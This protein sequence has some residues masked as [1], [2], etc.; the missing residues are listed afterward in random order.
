MASHNELG[1]KGEALTEEY[2]LRNGYQVLAKNWRY[3]KAEIDIIAKKGDVLAIIEVK[4]RTSV[5]I[6]SPEAAVNSKKIKLL[7]A[8][9]NEYVIQNDLD[10]EVRFDIV[11]IHKKNEKYN[12]N[13]IKDAFLFF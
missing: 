4:T 12:M 3:L 8:A 2:L 9:A 13:H 10:V 7:V 5:D 11:A 1:R 6:I